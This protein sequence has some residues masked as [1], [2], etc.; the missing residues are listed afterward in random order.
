MKKT[1]AIF[2]W[3]Q[4]KLSLM[5]MHIPAGNLGVTNDQQNSTS[6]LSSQSVQICLI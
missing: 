3:P 5:Q 6:E 4:N 2:F 1:D